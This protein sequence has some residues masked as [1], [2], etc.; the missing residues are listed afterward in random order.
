ADRAGRRA[1]VHLEIDSGMARQGAAPGVELECVVA[2]LH[3]SKWLRLEGVFSH[4]SSSEVREGK[5]T[6]AQLQRLQ[7]ALR[8]IYAEGLFVPELLHLAN[9]SA[10]DEGST[11]E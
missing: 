10:L 8:T 1:A 2:A 5:R 11:M 6:A 3:R 4:L 7:E 9:S